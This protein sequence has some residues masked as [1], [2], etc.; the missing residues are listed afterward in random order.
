LLLGATALASAV[1][2][3]DTS[4]LF[5]RFFAA[6][7]ETIKKTAERLWR[8]FG[9]PAALQPTTKTQIISARFVGIFKPELQANRLT[10][11]PFSGAEPDGQ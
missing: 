11:L 5:D 3:D 6:G 1:R 9:C 10:F 4:G 7:R 2:R 8:F